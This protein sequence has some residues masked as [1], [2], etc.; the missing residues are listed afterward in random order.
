V[1]AKGIAPTDKAKALALY[2]T[3]LRQRC[4]SPGLAV[5]IFLQI[6]LPDRAYRLV[7]DTGI[8]WLKA[9]LHPGRRDKGQKPA[10][11]RST[12]NALRVS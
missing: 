9:G 1:I 11:P 12:S 2:L 3:A 8:G 6:F 7:A 10:A 4:Y 5:I